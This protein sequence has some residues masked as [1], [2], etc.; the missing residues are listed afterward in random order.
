MLDVACVRA[1][2]E[3]TSVR[4][5]VRACVLTPDLAYL[6]GLPAPPPSRCHSLFPSAIRESRHTPPTSF[7]LV[8]CGLIVLVMCLCNVVRVY[9]RAGWSLRKT[10][11]PNGIERYLASAGKDAAGRVPPEP[12]TTGHV[13]AAHPAQ[14]TST[15]NGE[16]ADGVTASGGAAANDS[17]SSSSDGIRGAGA[18][19]VGE[20][21]S[22]SRSGGG[23]G[24]GAPLLA[25][26]ASA[27]SGGSRASAR[28]SGGGDDAIGSINPITGAPWEDPRVTLTGA[29]YLY[30]VDAVGQWLDDAVEG[31]RVLGF[32]TLQVR[33]GRTRSPSTPPPSAAVYCLCG[34]QLFVRSCRPLLLSPALLVRCSCLRFADAH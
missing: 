17:S 3:R 8:R 23:G 28:H 19:P 1:N 12:S 11:G 13:H 27:T 16:G 5:C 15:S 6:Y 18:V 30:I 29:A 25:R 10:D 4:A 32:S 31:R 7:T 20:G 34:R 24:A 26:S 22:S 14:S 21:L 9:S 2:C 33:R